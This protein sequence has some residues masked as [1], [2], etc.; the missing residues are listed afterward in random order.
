MRRLAAF[1][2][3]AYLGAPAFAETP[4]F[5][6]S[7]HT[8]LHPVVM[9]PGTAPALIN[10]HVLFLNK[11]TGGCQLHAGNNSDSTQ[12]ISDIAGGNV[13]LSAFAAG[14]SNWQAV[15][16]CV[17]GIMAPYNITVTDV[18]PGSAPH[19]EVMVAGVASQLNSQLGGQGI[20]GIADYACQS[21]GQC[22]APY[23]PNDIVFAFAND[24]YYGSAG[25]YDVL[26]VC[27]TAAQEIAHAW[28]LDHTI[29]RS[30]PMTYNQYTSPLKFAN[31]VQCGSDCQN[32]QGP[33]GETCTGQN[34]VCMSTGQNTQDEDTIIKK[35]FGP[36]GAA[37]PTVKFVTP[38][39]G[40]AQHQGFTVEVSC[41]SPDGVQEVDLTLDGL[42]VSTLTT[43]PYT[44]STSTAISKGNHHIEA[45]CG[46]NNQ[47][48]A[49]ASADFLVGDVCATDADCMM[50]Y[51]CYDK[52]CVAGP[53]ATGGLGAACTSNSDCSSGECASDGTHMY[54]VIPC[55]TT[56]AMCPSGFGCL[57]AG[58]GGV[59]WAGADNGGGGGG[60]CDTGNNGAAGSIVLGLGFAA[61]LITRRKRKQ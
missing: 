18:D 36:A 7:G 10:S 43:A 50:D 56:A 35:L 31:G 52:A 46:T 23:I 45:L 38:T 24:P 9:P 14:D 6:I 26:E 15:M 28:T 30:D 61:T 32:G 1:A 25:N 29:S 27:G 57:K 16:S 21:P 13:Q 44:Y 42:Q 60:C 59:C 41:T 3:L 40:S 34:H 17:K 19:F 33:F 54:C 48:V 58:A 11:C 20:L 2:V 49:T 22:Y 12:G 47:A 37:A 51:I 53:M 5:V 55:D 8:A 4:K 39:N